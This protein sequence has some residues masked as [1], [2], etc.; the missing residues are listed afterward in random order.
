MGLGSSQKK[1]SHK[2]DTEGTKSEESSHGS[3]C[4]GSEQGLCNTVYREKHTV[5]YRCPGY[6]SQE[7]EICI[8]I[9]NAS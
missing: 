8:S 5:M 3:V 9:L 6:S 7:K 2:Q 1:V 4:H